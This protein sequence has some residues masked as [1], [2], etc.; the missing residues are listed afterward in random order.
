MTVRDLASFDSVRWVVEIQHPAV[1]LTLQRIV[2]GWE[3]SIPEEA[4]C[5]VLLAVPAQQ[6]YAGISEDLR[7]RMPTSRVRNLPR[8]TH[9]VTVTP[10]GVGWTEAQRYAIEARLIRAL[11]S[12]VNRAAGRLLVPDSAYLDEVVAEAMR[13]VAMV[14][15]PRGDGAIPSQASAARDLVLSQHRHPYT[16]GTLVARLQDLGWSAGGQTAHRTLRRDLCDAGRGGHASIRA[17]G[18]WGD[19]G[20]LVYVDGRAY[21]SGWRPRRKT[22]D[23]GTGS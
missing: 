8:A 6:A 14:C 19:D 3:Q 16:V 22:G 4:G 17:H 10:L 20:T 1:R 11:G 7:D 12:P 9:A 21:T 18:R 5:Y 23:R 15:P 2:P 13:L